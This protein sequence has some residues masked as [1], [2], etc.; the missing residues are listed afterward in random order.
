MKYKEQGKLMAGILMILSLL[1][2]LDALGY[3]ETKL[4]LIENIIVLAAGI[5]IVYLGT[6]IGI[7]VGIVLGILS[8]ANMFAIP[9]IA[10]IFESL[11]VIIFLTIVIL[12]GY[13]V[14]K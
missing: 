2:T 9:G 7:M 5:L 12:L 13:I 3:I 14:I 4:G 6:G 8:I 11:K 1:L 10:L